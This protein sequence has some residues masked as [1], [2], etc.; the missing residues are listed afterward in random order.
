MTIGQWGA[1]YEWFEPS[2]NCI[3]LQS[4]HL[5]QAT[6]HHRTAILEFKK[7]PVQRCR[8]EIPT[9]QKLMRK[10]MRKLMGMRKLTHE[11]AY[12]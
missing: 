4:I 1:N 6:M 2:S 8:S 7:I 12:V 5:N 10:F 11:K 9:M 3:I